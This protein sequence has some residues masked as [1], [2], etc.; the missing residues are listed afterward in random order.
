MS[1]RTILTEVKQEQFVNPLENATKATLKLG[2]PIAETTIS[3][4]DKHDLLIDADMQFVGEMKFAVTGDTEKVVMLS[5]TKDSWLGWLNPQNWIHQSQNEL[6]SYI[7]LTPRIPLALD[8]QGGVG[9]SRLDLTGLN[10]TSVDMNGGI[11]EMDIILP[12]D[13]PALKVGIQV[14]VGQVDLVIPPG[15]GEQAQIKG[16]VGE[17]EI[18]L[19]PNAA[20]RI[21]ARSG[22]G[23]LDIRYPGL[24]KISGDEG[25]LGFMGVDGVWE[26]EG[27]SLATNP[28]HIR[29]EGGVGQLEVR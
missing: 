9:E 29:Y 22:I 15:T 26:T 12:A 21:E 16:G 19:P 7:R 11:G 17:T 8:V 18:R 10:V 4:G 6:R 28:I 2:L 27:Y 13:I 20:V 14:G 5:P 25:F 23:N 1:N 3:R 24:K